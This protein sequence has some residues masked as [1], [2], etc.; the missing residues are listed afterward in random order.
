MGKKSPLITVRPSGIV[1]S[2]PAAGS[3]LSQFPAS[4]QTLFMVPVKVV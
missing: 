2:L 3:P 1:A 4:A